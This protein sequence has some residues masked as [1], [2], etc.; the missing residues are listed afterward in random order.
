MD[1]KQSLDSVAQS[2][3]RDTI[4]GFVMQGVQARAQV[5][6]LSAQVQELQRQLSELKTDG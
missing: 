3:L 2:I 4:G 6:I 5:E 1:S